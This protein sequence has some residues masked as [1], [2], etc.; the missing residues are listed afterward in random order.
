MGIRARPVLDLIQ[1]LGSWI[2]GALT[3]PWMS[4]TDQPGCGCPGGAGHRCRSCS[5]LF[6]ADCMYNSCHGSAQPKLCSNC[7][8]TIAGYLKTDDPETPPRSPVTSIS[9]GNLARLSESPKSLRCSTRRNC[10]EDDYY[11]PLSAVSQDNSSSDTDYFSVK[12]SPVGSPKRGRTS[13]QESPSYLRRYGLDVDM[14][15]SGSD[16]AYGN[17][18][19]CDGDESA[20]AKE[21]LD[22]DF[23]NDSV[24]WHPP[25]AL[26][27]EDDVETLF[28]YEDDDGY[29]SDS[30]TALPSATF[31]CEGLF[32]KEKTNNAKKAH[33]KSTFREHFTALVSQLLEAEGL[34]VGSVDGV[35]R[36]GWLA[37]V[38]SLAWQT[39]DI[40]KPD[41]SKGGSMD[42]GHYVKVKCVP[43][44]APSD[45]MV[46]KG[47][48]CTKNVKH[49]HMMSQHRQPRLLLLG[50]AL[51]VPNELASIN[52]VLEQETEHLKM[53]VSKIEAHRPNVLLVEKNVSSLVQQYL[54]SMEISLVLNVKRTLLER[55]ARCTGAQIASS[56]YNLDSVRTGQC[57]IFRVEKVFEE[58]SSSTAP[59]KKSVKT[60]MFFEGCPRRL[61]CTVLLKGACLEEL[62]KVKGVMQ[63]A[64]FAAYHL[65]LQTSFLADEGASLPKVSGNLP[66]VISERLSANECISGD[67]SHLSLPDSQNGEHIDGSTQNPALDGTGSPMLESHCKASSQFETG[68]KIYEARML[69]K[70]FENPCDLRAADELNVN[71]MPHFSTV[72]NHDSILVS[73]SSSC[74]RKGTVCDGSR[75]F[76]IKYYHSSDKPLG[77][78]LRDDLFDQISSCRTCQE[79]VEAHVRCY[80]HQQGTLTISVKRLPS[81]KLSGERDGRIWMWHRCLKCGRKDGIPPASHRVVM[82]AA[83]LG[84]SF[85][86]FLE[87]SFSNHSTANRVASCGHSLQRDC[88]R[89]YGLGSMVAYFRYSPV[90]ILSI[91]LPP[92]VLDFSCDVQPDWMRREAAAIL[93]K[94]ENLHGEVSNVLFDV[95][96]RVT[97]SE[98]EPLSTSLHKYI[99]DLRELLKRERYEY[100]DLVQSAR[101]DNTGPSCPSLDVLELNRLGHS[102]VI[103]SYA[104][105]RRLH[106]LDSI[107]RGTDSSAI[108]DSQPSES[109][110]HS[111][112]RG[113]TSQKDGTVQRLPEGTEMK[114]STL[115]RTSRNSTLSKQH[116]ET[117]LQVLECNSNNLVE[118]DISI[119]SVQG[120]AGLVGLNLI[121]GQSCRWDEKQIGTEDFID[122]SLFDDNTS[123]ENNLSDKIDLLWTGSGLTL[124][125]LK[126]NA[127]TNLVG[128]FMD[129]PHCRNL[130][131]PARVYSFDSSMRY[132]NKISGLAASSQHFS[133]V[134]SFD[135]SGN[136][137]KDPIQNMRQAYTQRSL[138]ATRSL[139][140]L[141][142]QIP[143]ASHMVSEGARFLLS[144]PGLDDIV[145]LV[146]DDDLTSIISYAISA[147]EH[148]NFVVSKSDQYMGLRENQKSS[149]VNKQ[150]GYCDGPSTVAPQDSSSQ[151]HDDFHSSRGNVYTNPKEPHFRFSFEDDSSFPTDKVKFTVKCYFARQFDALRKKCCPSEVDF[152]RSLSR[153]KR[154][155]AQG[156]KSNVYFAKSWDE[157]FIIKQVTR[158][159]LYSFEEFAPEYFKYMTESIENG[160][161]TCLAKVLGIY[162]V[163]VKHLKGGR[164]VKMDLIVMENLFFQRN[165]S[166]VYDLKGSVRSRYNSDTSVNKVLLDLNLLETIRSKPIFL[167]SK[168]K[169]RLERAVWND[170]S[171]LASIDVMD[172]SLLVGMDDDNKVLVVGIIDIMRQYTWDKHL[173]TWVK[174]SGILGGPKNASPTVISPVQYKKRFRKA[175][176]SYFLTFPDQW[177][178]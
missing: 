155:K 76:R 169:R 33:L 140:F 28:R 64:S 56:V 95:E 59:S 112:M 47:V 68:A 72:D 106:L 43:S 84:L 107:S 74:I 3:K 97:T 30:G 173:E 165:I 73:S 34:R 96:Q 20:P 167:G 145:L 10:E 166:R 36:D 53:F 123:P 1:K 124:S 86:K 115:F 12:S 78:Y 58:C 67:V 147:Q 51:G 29:A 98:H 139:N 41:T 35:A 178:S 150:I 48:V 109:L 81:V 89:F 55:I 52:T 49:K 171:F 164:E 66:M 101:A 154:W 162:Q 143:S 129:N 92:L 144:R 134:K 128:S 6:C 138:R 32:V 25:P 60:L 122:G 71:D 170:T 116:V 177:S 54:L 87:L 82:S 79:P 45:S 24:L 151:F 174:A 142:N 16:C 85:G 120:Y 8:S 21:Q 157:R 90:D 40:V 2:G 18:A 103:D 161:P 70:D 163:H 110:T 175:M 136:F 31:D 105:D 23:E 117:S 119:E 172:Y 14:L 125:S 65:S 149:T 130:K 63:F 93:N 39:A 62:K 141:R 5:R 100:D 13:P 160:S 121:S 22:F 104:W 99:S 159:E 38:S 17:V 61:G 7:Y 126:I 44:G 4:S 153:S 42:P 152:I 77:M 11:S 83:A 88:L 132:Q 168:A 111:K 135:M 118:M 19:V 137:M 57:E 91:E 127:E 50:G 69:K 26:E 146:H 133:S 176:S 156:G 148:A 75:L 46:I 158:T 113:V 108:V 9:D 102:L 27:E 80:M 15:E 94:L 131:T 37:V 114:L